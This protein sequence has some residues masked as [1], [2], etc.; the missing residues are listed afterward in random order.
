MKQKRIAKWLMMHE[1]HIAI[2]P[3]LWPEYS[4][5]NQP[6]TWIIKGGR[7]IGRGNKTLSERSDFTTYIH[8]HRVVKYCLLFY[9]TVVTSN[10]AFSGAWQCHPERKKP[11]VAPWRRKPVGKRTNSING[12]RKCNYII[13][14]DCRLNYKVVDRTIYGKFRGS[15]ASLHFGRLRIKSCF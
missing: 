5:T 9:R 8:Y 15:N 12:T 10:E 13:F 1:A 2:D 7:A 6:R 11:A 4:N 14:G 3:N